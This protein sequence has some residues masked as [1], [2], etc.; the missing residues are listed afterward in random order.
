MSKDVG[1][2]WL[3]TVVMNIKHDVSPALIKGLVLLVSTA[4]Q[5]T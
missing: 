2:K 5:C 4:Q 3:D 1:G